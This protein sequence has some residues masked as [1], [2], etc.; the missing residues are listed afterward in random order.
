MARLPPSCCRVTFIM[1]KTSSPDDPLFKSFQ[2]WFNAQSNVHR[3]N[4]DE[5]PDIATFRKWD[6]GT[7]DK[8][9]PNGPY[10]NEA[11]WFAKQTLDW[12]QGKLAED[13]FQRGDYRELCQ[14][15][16][17]VLGGKVSNFELYS[18]YLV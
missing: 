8:D 6:W 14:L 9:S 17:F 18:S 11:N 12:V 5:F 16:N 10:F 13:I 1:H 7:E 2:D 3:E 4:G 15:I